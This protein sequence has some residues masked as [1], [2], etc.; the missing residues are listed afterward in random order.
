MTGASELP[1]VAE[2]ID[3]PEE[4]KWSPPEAGAAVQSEKKSPVGGHHRH[5][6]STPWGQKGIMLGHLRQLTKSKSLALQVC[7]IHVL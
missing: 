6:T 2:D 4:G 1:S 7:I 5:V 3:N